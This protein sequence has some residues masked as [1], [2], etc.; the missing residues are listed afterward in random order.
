MK[1][2]RIWS[3][4]IVMLAIKYLINIS[5]GLFIGATIF[6]YIFVKNFGG[7]YGFEKTFQ[8]IAYGMTPLILLEWI[9]YVNILAVIYASIL[10]IIGISKLQKI[11]IKKATLMYI[12]FIIISAIITYGIQHFSSRP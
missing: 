3:L 6:H 7:S 4:A 2:R 11:E 8:A 1:A 9:P 5:I 12:I 10:T